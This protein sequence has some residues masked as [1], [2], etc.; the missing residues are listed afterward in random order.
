[1]SCRVAYMWQ[2]ASSAVRDLTTNHMPTCLPSLTSSRWTETPVT[3]QEKTNRSHS[4]SS[5][6]SEMNRLFRKS[7]ISPAWYHLSL[8]LWIPFGI[9]LRLRGITWIC[10]HAWY[11]CALNRNR[12]IGRGTTNFPSSKTFTSDRL[13]ENH[14]KSSDLLVLENLPSSIFVPIKWSTFSIDGCH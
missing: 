7:T 5:A 3:E 11:R 12:T 2:N 9:I 10:I 6:F 4:V 1:M 14:S 13:N 8:S